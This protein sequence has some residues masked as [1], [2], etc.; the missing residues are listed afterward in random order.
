MN[1]ET[2]EI[3]E[4]P[5]HKSKATPTGRSNHEIYKY[6]QVKCMFKIDAKEVDNNDLTTTF[7]L[8]LV[9]EK[10]GGKNQHNSKLPLVET[11]VYA[12]NCASHDK[13]LKPCTDCVSF[14][15]SDLK[16]WLDEKTDKTGGN[17]DYDGYDDYGG[18]YSDYSDTPES[19]KFLCQWIPQ[20][21]SCQRTEKNSDYKIESTIDSPD[22]HEKCPRVLSSSVASKPIHFNKS[23]DIDNVVLK[24]DSRLMDQYQNPKWKCIFQG[25]VYSAMFK[26]D[27]IAN[28]QR[29][30]VQTK[31]R[32]GCKDSKLEFKYLPSQIIDESSYSYQVNFQL[33]EGDNDKHDNIIFDQVDTVYQQEIYRCGVKPRSNDCS[34]CVQQNKY[35]VV[36]RNFVFLVETRFFFGSFEVIFGPKHVILS[37]LWA[38]TCN[39]RSFRG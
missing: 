4:E 8:R 22:N 27:R 3:D 13:S 6:K 20:K 12:Y 30:Y 33:Q 37:H 35:R 29:N 38:K 36:F 18:S 31:Y 15:E 21:R 25:K 24:I 5:V 17:D 14:K 16:A 7:K 32:G 26:K 9:L 2:G 34:T 19:S 23:A 39:F 10:F 1:L 11:H 28:K